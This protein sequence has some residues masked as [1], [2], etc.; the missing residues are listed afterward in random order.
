MSGESAMNPFPGVAALARTEE[1]FGNTANFDS[2]HCPAS[3]G[4]GEER[5]AVKLTS[6]WVRTWKQTTRSQTNVSAG[7]SAL[8]P[9]A[10]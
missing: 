1:A 3:A 2:S 4:N 5:S 8:P 9:M 7:A 10:V 6:R